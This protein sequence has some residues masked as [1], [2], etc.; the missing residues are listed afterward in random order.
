MATLTTKLID[1][2]HE[3]MRSG[4]IDIEPTEIEKFVLHQLT[5][6]LKDLNELYQVPT[7]IQSLNKNLKQI[8]ADLEPIIKNTQTKAITSVAKLREL[9]NRKFPKG[10]SPLDD[11]KVLKFAESL[12]KPY[13]S[14]VE[15]EK[16]TGISRQTVS[17][18]IENGSLKSIESKTGRPKV[19]PEEVINLF[20]EHKKLKLDF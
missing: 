16:L 11:E 13:Y 3:I 9:K 10:T 19:P 18:R 5:I 2:L 20:R 6:G 1:L 8:V 7:K 4:K 12:T 15:T 17:T 14:F